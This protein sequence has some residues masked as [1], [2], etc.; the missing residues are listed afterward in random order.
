[1]DPTSTI[2]P[3]TVTSD[4]PVL[5][6]ATSCVV[7]DN[8]ILA[9][10]GS[11]ISDL[12]RRRRCLGSPNT[13]RQIEWPWSMVFTSFFR[14]WEM[15]KAGCF[16]VSRKVINL[17]TE[18]TDPRNWPSRKYDASTKVRAE[19]ETRSLIPRETWDQEDRYA[20]LNSDQG[21]GAEDVVVARRGDIVCDLGERIHIGHS[22]GLVV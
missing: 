9:S 10:S 20:G 19:N 15:D 16:A 5:M 8:C 21:Q 14:P 4:T 22:T 6:S 11:T 7:S 13:S 1:M 3:P 17:V 2:V 12:K 18:S